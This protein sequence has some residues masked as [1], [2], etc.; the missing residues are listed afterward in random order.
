[1]IKALRYLADFLEQEKCQF[2]V[3]WNGLL[4]NLKI[5][6]SYNC[7]NCLCEKLTK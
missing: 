6:K 2:I 4:D 1:M 7:E 3:Y 5:I